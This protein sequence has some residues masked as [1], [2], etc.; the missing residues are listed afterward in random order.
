MKTKS[1]GLIEAIISTAIMLLFITGIFYLSAKSVKIHSKYL[2]Q[3]FVTNVSKDFFSR[4]KI[5]QKSG[6][7]NFSGQTNSHQ[8]SLD[9]FDSSKALDCLG[10]LSYD[11]SLDLY[12]FKDLIKA[13]HDEYLKIDDSKYFNSALR[14][15][16][17]RVKSKLSDAGD[18]KKIIELEFKCDYATQ[19][20]IYKTSQVITDI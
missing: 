3:E 11:S 15:Y 9:C 4:A 14:A 19:T 8:I 17:F 12:P 18:G 7:L 16:N 5:L 6:Y 20:E 2:R 10:S 13:T 1:F